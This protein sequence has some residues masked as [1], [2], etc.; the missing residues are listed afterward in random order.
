[1]VLKLCDFAGCSQAADY[2]LGSCLICV[3]HLCSLHLSP[4]HHKCPSAVSSSP[5]PVVSSF[6]S[7]TIATS[8]SSVV[9]IFRTFQSND[10]N[11]YRRACYA[12]ERGQLAAQLDRLDI[13]ALKDVASRTRRG[14]GVSTSICHIPAL[15]DPIDNGKDTDL[16]SRIERIQCCGGQNCN[17]EIHFTD[18]VV[19]IARIRLENIRMPPTSV[20]E[21]VTRSEAATYAFLATTTVPTP[22]VYG[23]GLA[24]DAE[25]PV[26]MTYMLMEKAAGHP[27]QWHSIPESQKRKVLEQLATIYIELE[28]HP[29]SHMGSLDF[30]A[31]EKKNDPEIGIGPFAEIPYF[32]TP[33]QSLGPFSTLR[34]SLHAILGR[35]ADAIRTGER[36]GRFPLDNYI[37]IL[38]RADHVNELA[39]TSRN[40]GPFYLTHAEDKGNHIMVDDANNITAII[41][42]EWASSQ[43]REIAFASPCMLWPEAA[44]YKGSNELSQDERL[45]A[46]VLE[47]IGR[48]DLATLV[49]SGRRWQRFLF[50]LGGF[51]R[52][53]SELH[54]LFQGLR[55]A[56]L[57]DGKK[58]LSTYSQWK[59]AY[60]S[61]DLRED[62]RLAQWTIE[63]GLDDKKANVQ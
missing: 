18:G 60:L 32:T 63:D 36:A 34:E 33:D 13:A 53:R 26:G 31:R 4:T 42:W 62:P 23:Y 48:G 51:P 44:F 50:F 46:S 59:K 35:T 10:A 11:I 28:K 29:F 24:S 14:Q 47:D 22:R 58:E 39:S 21:Y 57:D 55:A 16:V 54:G 45:Y 8:A 40:N 6:P 27:L 43:P 49:R 9:L 15:E 25:N 52:G 7:S 17:L 41:D 3:L 20:Q 61:S 56:F 2:D 30:Q 12:S 37:G 5:S 1:M 19:W 38:W